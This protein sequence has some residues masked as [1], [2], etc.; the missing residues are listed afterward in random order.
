LN[1]LDSAW[2]EPIEYRLVYQPADER[3]V[4]WA[5]AMSPKFVHVEVWRLLDVG[6]WLA[7]QP[8]HDFLTFNLV[9]GE[10][11]GV[12]QRVQARRVRGTPLAPIGLKTCVTVAKAAL[13]LRNP[14]II[15]PLQLYR[16]I[17]SNNGVI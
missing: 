15:T 10:P 7:L 17:A 11:Q 5:R 16:H 14:W 6:Y 1:L 8:Y 4:W 12:V 13:G 3:T 2:A 9:E